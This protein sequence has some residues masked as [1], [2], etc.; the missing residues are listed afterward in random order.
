MMRINFGA[1]KAE[2]D[3]DEKIQPA[4]EHL[5]LLNASVKNGN[6]ILFKKALD[7]KLADKALMD[8]FLS[9]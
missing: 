4:R 9:I 3:N 8:L 7:K 6:N 2:R 1:E 5:L